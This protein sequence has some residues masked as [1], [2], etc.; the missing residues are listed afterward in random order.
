M[1]TKKNNRRKALAVGFAIVGV[2]GLSLASASQLNLSW[3][4]Q[5]QAGNVTVEGECQESPISVAF[6]A[7]TFASGTTNPWTVQSV[8]FS[9]IDADCDGKQYRVA[10]K[11]NGAWVALADGAA[12]TGVLT[13]S[14]PAGVDP[15][16]I[17]GFA[18]SIA[19]A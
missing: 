7:P 8:T 18:L 19:N 3:A 5:Y 4:G 17:T 14:A 16:T 1:S 9:S 12:A 6:S 13:V 2:A 15:S 10:Y 11:T